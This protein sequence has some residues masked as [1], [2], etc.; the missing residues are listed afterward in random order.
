VIENLIY[1][2]VFAPSYIVPTRLKVGSVPILN[3]LKLDSK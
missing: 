2:K 3:M 1:V